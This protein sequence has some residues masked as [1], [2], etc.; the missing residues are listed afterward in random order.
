MAR[1]GKPAGNKKTSF[2]KRTEAEKSFRERKK[3]T[4][5]E[6][7]QRSG[8]GKFSGPSKFSSS[9]FDKEK[10][11]SEDRPSFGA[12]PNSDRPF[13]K[14]PSSGFRRDGEGSSPGFKKEGG[15]TSPRENRFSK[16]GNFSKPRF[17]RDKPRSE[18]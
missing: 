2:G 12:K 15:N 7:S 8:R 1:T 14:K 4:R 17:D 3:E 11:R 10:P 18:G 6:S 13:R 16:T 5:G 9:R